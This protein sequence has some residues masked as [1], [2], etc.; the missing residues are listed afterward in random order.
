MS[1]YRPHPRQKRTCEE[2][3]AEL[4]EENYHLRSELQTEEIERLENVSEE[5]ISE[6][7]SEISSLKNQLYQARKDMR[8]KGKYIS[9]L[10]ER[11]VESEEQVEK[12]RYQIK[13]ISSQKNS[14]ERGN[15]PDLYNPNINLKMTT[16]TELANAIDEAERD[17][18]IIRR[19]NAEEVEQMAIA[20]FHQLKTST[21][22]LVE[23]MANNITRKKTQQLA[24]ID[25]LGAEKFAL[26]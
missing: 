11:L 25:E 3:K 7:K 1:F 12:L 26:Q 4:E 14:S 8:D 15:S 13:T 23:R 21:Q 9:S 5:E 6:L 2:H 10:E 19:Q 18:K 16:I 20:D 22:N 24:R 17:N